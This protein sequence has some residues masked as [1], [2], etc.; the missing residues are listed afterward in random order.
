VMY[1]AQCNDKEACDSGYNRMF[2]VGD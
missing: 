1:E 2:K